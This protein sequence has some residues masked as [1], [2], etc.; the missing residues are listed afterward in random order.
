MHARQ[1]HLVVTDVFGGKLEELDGTLAA[2]YRDDEL[3]YISPMFAADGAVYF[4]LRSG[5]WRNRAQRTD[6]RI[7]H[8]VDGEFQVI[9][10]RVTSPTDCADA[11]WSQAL[12]QTLLPQAKAT[13][14]A[15]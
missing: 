8:I 1:L 10:A 13:F 7:G 9:E 3:A 14:S 4:I 15:P 2:A 6:C 5:N 12:G 11:P